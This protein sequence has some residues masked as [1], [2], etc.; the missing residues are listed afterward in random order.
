M[1]VSL[2]SFGP[3]LV[4]NSHHQKDGKWSIDE[5]SIDSVTKPEANEPCRFSGG[6]SF[7][8]H[9]AYIVDRLK[10]CIPKLWVK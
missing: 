5:G 4:M 2:L 3:R 7:I 1:A 9:R 8:T 6:D 10:R